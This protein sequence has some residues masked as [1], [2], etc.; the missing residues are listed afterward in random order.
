MYLNESQG[1]TAFTPSAFDRKE[2]RALHS[3]GRPLQPRGP[4]TSPQ[5]SNWGLALQPR[6]LAPNPLPNSSANLSASLSR[7]CNHRTS[8]PPPHSDPMSAS[9]IPGCVTWFASSAGAAPGREIRVPQGAN[10]PSGRAFCWGDFLWALMPAWNNYC[11]STITGCDRWT[12]AGGGPP[13]IQ[14]WLGGATLS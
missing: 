6:L 14:I 2:Y 9:S 11:C 3:D 4:H 8:N 10:I 7:S 13:S 12:Q 1:R 5:P